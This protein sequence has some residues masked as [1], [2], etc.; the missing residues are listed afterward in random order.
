MAVLLVEVWK[1]A[2]FK[3]SLRIAGRAKAGE[4]ARDR[5]ARAVCLSRVGRMME[6]IVSSLSLSVSVSPSMAFRSKTRI[7]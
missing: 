7:K 4:A 3:M 1:V 6:A 2:A 5:D